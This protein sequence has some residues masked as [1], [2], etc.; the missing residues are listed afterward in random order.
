MN[1]LNQL[2]SF[3]SKSEKKKLSFLFLMMFLSA[4]FELIGLSLIIPIITLGLK[5]NLTDIFFFY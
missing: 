3:F 5:Q 2:F 4:L 1:Q